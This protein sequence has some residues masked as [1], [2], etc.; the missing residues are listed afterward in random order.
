MPALVLPTINQHAKL[1]MPS[2]KNFKGL[3]GVHLSYLSMCQSA[4]KI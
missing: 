1:E 3:I 2:L 4:N